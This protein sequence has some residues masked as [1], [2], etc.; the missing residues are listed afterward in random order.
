MSEARKLVEVIDQ[1]EKQSE[2]LNSAIDLYGEISNLYSKI[3]NTSEE[4][5]KL[6]EDI[7]KAK[8]SL[9]EA[10]KNIK[11]TL[12]SSNNEEVL[13]KI[14]CSINYNYKVT[15]DTL[16][17]IKK[18]L[19]NVITDFNKFD[20]YTIT[21]N[22]NITSINDNTKL[23]KLDS[24]DINNKVI[25]LSKII[26]NLKNIIESNKSEYDNKLEKSIKKLEEN[27]LINQ[28]N[29]KNEVITIID[30]RLKIIEHEYKKNIKNIYICIGIVAA[31]SVVSI[32]IK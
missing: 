13:D 2:E 17:I 10:N 26:L 23:L 16:E 24:N 28:E 1:L 15:I 12:E 11:N 29:K 9:E 25:E 4:Y 21:L 31:I 20:S 6:F 22:N 5:E 18:Y 3:S 8:L 30:N 7:N 27:I 19:D 32:F 14:Y